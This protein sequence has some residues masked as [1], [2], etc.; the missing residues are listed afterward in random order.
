MT[1]VSAE[2]ADNAARELQLGLVHVEVHAVDA[3]DLEGDV[4]FEDLCGIAG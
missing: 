4:V 3:L 2:E 1:A